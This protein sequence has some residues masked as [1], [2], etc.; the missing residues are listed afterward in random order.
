MKY[1]YQEL[2]WLGKKKNIW[3]SCKQVEETAAVAG[4]EERPR[5][6][7]AICLQGRQLSHF[8]LRAM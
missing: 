4:A 7:T 1:Q 8:W 3:K 5:R 6:L 2:Q